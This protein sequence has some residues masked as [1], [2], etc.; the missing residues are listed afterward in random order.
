MDLYM[1]L[2]SLIALHSNKY[3]FKQMKKKV[4]NKLEAAYVSLMCNKNKKVFRV[5][6]IRLFYNRK[7]Y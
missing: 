6:S 4:H 2:W 1:V 3:I 5:K 7:F